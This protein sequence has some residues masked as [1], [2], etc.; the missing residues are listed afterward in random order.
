[1]QLSV[2]AYIGLIGAHRANSISN[3]DP[4]LGYVCHAE[5]LLRAGADPNYGGAPTRPAPS[6]QQRGMFSIGGLP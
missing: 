3:R 6:F 4:T 2:Y 5:Y 1:M